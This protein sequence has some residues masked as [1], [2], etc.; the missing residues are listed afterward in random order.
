MEWRPS[1]VKKREWKVYI[2]AIS[3]FTVYVVCRARMLRNQKWLMVKHAT[4]ATSHGHRKVQKKHHKIA[5]DIARKANTCL[6]GPSRTATSNGK[7]VISFEE[8]S[9]GITL[10]TVGWKNLR[11]YVS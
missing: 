1:T 3:K 4:D 7:T 8:S 11:W 5:T 10:K 6:F 2:K 9:E